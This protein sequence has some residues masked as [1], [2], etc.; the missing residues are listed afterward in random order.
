MVA[1][2]HLRFSTDDASGRRIIFAII[3]QVITFTTASF[4]PYPYYGIGLVFFLPFVCQQA[5]NLLVTLFVFPETLAHQFADRLIATLHPLQDVIR[6]QKTLLGTNPRSAEWLKFKSVRASAN[7]ALGGVALLGM[8]EANLTRE[9]A[10]ARVPGGDLTKLLAATRVVVARTAGFVSFYNVVE[11]HLH[12][13]SSESKGGA[14]ANDLVI[15]LD[16]RSRPNSPDGTP[17]HSRPGSLRRG[18]S[19]DGNQHEPDSDHLAVG[20]P[21]PLAGPSPP[22]STWRKSS[23]RALNSAS[24]TSSSASLADLDEHHASEPSTSIGF[25]HDLPKPDRGSRKRSKSRHRTGHTH[26]SSSHLSLSSLLHDVLHPHI[27]TRRVG[28]VESVRYADLEDYL[29]NPHDQQHLEEII[30]HLS[31]ATT[32]L[33]D[34]LD[35]ALGHLVT[36]IHRIKRY[37]SIWSYVF[38]QPEQDYKNNVHATKILGDELKAALAKYRDDKRLEVVRPYAHLFDPTVGTEFDKM[39]APSHRGM[40]WA[41]SYQHCCMSWGD[42][43]VEVYDQVATVEEKRRKPKLW[44]PDWAKFRF[45]HNTAEASF[46]DENP[47]AAISGLNEHLWSAPRNPDASPPTTAW[48]LIGIRLSRFG[49]VV[50]RK[51]VLFG[52]KAAVVIVLCAL[53]AYFK[54]S[55]FFFYKQRGVW[56]LIMVSLAPLFSVFAVAF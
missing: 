36:S 15:H 33:I 24:R 11:S 48:H 42:A 6:T 25:Q 16:G 52:V 53:P 23:S 50:Q 8:S 1:S 5:I 17:Q 30:H 34:V 55:S 41:F 56:V 4:F 29:A 20:A 12:R 27:D 54:A 19:E 22:R 14:M 39:Q 43:L 21:S 26:K 49:S 2:A 10:F 38:P 31:A 46:E 51:D 32:E 44:A 3:L 40:F 13:D 35:A 9:I 37:D 47:D 7:A 45:G 28:V 18:D